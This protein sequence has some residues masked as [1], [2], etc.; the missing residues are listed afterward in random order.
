[1][2]AAAAV[3]TRSSASG[4]GRSPGAR[5]A[6]GGA[7]GSM[8]IIRPSASK[9]RAGVRSSPISILETGTFRERACGPLDVWT[10][11]GD[12]DSTVIVVFHPASPRERTH[13]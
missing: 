4:R 10:V 2:K 9:I 13:R 12:T 8:K 6:S 3:L 11:S 5:P 7:V 1:L